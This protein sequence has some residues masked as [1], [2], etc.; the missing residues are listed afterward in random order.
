MPLFPHWIFSS[1]PCCLVSSFLGIVV[2]AVGWCWWLVSW[3]CG[4]ILFS[5]LLWTHR[6]RLLSSFSCFCVSSGSLLCSQLP[7]S[8]SVC[9]CL[10]WCRILCQLP[11]MLALVLCCQSLFLAVYHFCLVFVLRFYGLV[12]VWH[13]NLLLR[14]SHY[15]DWG[16]WLGFQVV[17]NFSDL[18]QFFLFLGP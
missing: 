15:F 16:D 5:L 2:C 12:L 1:L 3:C 10:L 13:W 9:F 6:F 7:I 4:R 14:W 11:W 8:R 17:V 18:F